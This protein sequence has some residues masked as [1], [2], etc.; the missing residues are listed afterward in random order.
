V[1]DSLTTLWTFLSQVLSAD[2]SCRQ[3]VARLRAFLTAD[4]QPPCAPETGP[5]CKARQRLP[6][7]L[8][9]RLVRETASELQDRIAQ[10]ALLAGRPVK[11][12][13]GSTVSMPDT[14]ANQAAYP[15][16]AA[17]QPGLG[18]PLARIVALISLSCGAVLD[19]AIGPYQG[20]E[21]G[22]TALFREL[23][24]SLLEGDIVVGDRYFASFWDL[25][26][27][28]LGGADCVFRQH[29]LR[30]TRHQRIARLGVGDYLLR[31]PKPARPS[32][33]DRESY[34]RIPDELIVREVTVRIKV[35]GFRVHE[36][37]LVTTLCDA[38]ATSAAELA[39]VY[40]LRWHAEV[41]Q[42]DCTSSA[43]LY[44]VAG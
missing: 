17:Q 8:C 7:N 31:L 41:Y 16:S 29:Q 19:L 35:R 10:P 28:K 11:L 15:Q 12:V 4:G 40:R 5:Y 2:H 44:R 25:S 39:E 30:L 23:W 1:Y 22:E 42:L 43:G 34:R 9:A 14:A 20:K 36:L 32:W 38:T 6:E 26:L 37:T 24:R 3:A 33:M 13:D 27:L 21:T 18:F